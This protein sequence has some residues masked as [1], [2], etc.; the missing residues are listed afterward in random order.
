ME[1]LFIR[2]RKIPFT[3]SSIPGKEKLHLFW[4]VYLFGFM[5]YVMLMSSI[6]VSLFVK[7][8]RFFVFFG[9]IFFLIVSIRLYQNYFF[10]RKTELV[11]EEKLE[12]VLLGL[13]AQIE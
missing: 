13:E 11:Y 4:I 9:V 3:S 6:E 5:V 8:S 12:P 10:Y 7:P 2:F 1:I